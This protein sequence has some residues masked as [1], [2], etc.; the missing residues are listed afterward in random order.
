MFNFRYK[1]TSMLCYAN[2]N[3]TC[4]TE[5]FHIPA[6]MSKTVVSIKSG[7]TTSEFGCCLP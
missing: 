4:L 1:M 5:H 7:C 3:I 2:S 6:K